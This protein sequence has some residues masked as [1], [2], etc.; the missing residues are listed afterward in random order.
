MSLYVGNTFEE[1]YQAFQD[2]LKTAVATGDVTS[3]LSEEA[4][5]SYDVNVGPREQRT[6]KPGIMSS[7]DDSDYDIQ[8]IPAGKEPRRTN[9]K[10]G[11]QAIR[12]QGLPEGTFETLIEAAPLQDNPNQAIA[13]LTAVA[14]V[15]SNKDVMKQLE[16]ANQLMQAAPEAERANVM[17]MVQPDR[18][19]PQ[20]AK[21]AINAF[22][23]GDMDLKSCVTAIEG[24]RS[25]ASAK[26]NTDREND[27]NSRYLV[28][29]KKNVES[30]VAIMNTYEILQQVKDIPAFNER[31]TFKNLDNA[32]SKV[33]PD[34]DTYQELKGAME[35]VV[36]S[37]DTAIRDGI[38]TL[39]DFIDKNKAAIKES[40]K[41][42]NESVQNKTFRKTKPEA[43]ELR[44]A[45][46]TAIEGCN[47]SATFKHAIGKRQQTVTVDQNPQ[48]QKGMMSK[49]ADKVMHRSG[50]A[51]PSSRR[52][53]PK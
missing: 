47:G 7:N 14:S 22:K 30:L 10:N 48:P 18:N 27:I 15:M 17:K 35:K 24:A 40:R 1:A 23:N 52:P 11:T 21:E 50:D 53:G 8:I 16:Y 39:A 51:G 9:Y 42:I 29:N 41:D 26:S 38:A 45:T 5:F 31:T 34:N 43:A 2:E 46:V 13:N 49:L 44:K 25:E 4:L 28:D 3:F 33:I 12:A 37:D 36:S 6:L 19:V 20:G 32:V